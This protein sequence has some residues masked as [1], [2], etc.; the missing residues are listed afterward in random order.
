M[1]PMAVALTQ[2]GGGEDKYEEVGIRLSNLFWEI[3]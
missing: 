3:S 1:C 2:A